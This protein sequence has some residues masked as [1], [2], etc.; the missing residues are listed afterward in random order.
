MT[1]LLSDEEIVACW[2]AVRLEAAT[3]K[4]DFA[5]AIES[6]VLDKLK[7]QEPV[8]WWIETAE[9]FHIGPRPFARAWTP[10]YAGPML[11][12]A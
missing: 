8:A 1:Q 10:L 4:N 3:P 5:R 9:Q 12:P 6:A 11:P 7:R 2:N